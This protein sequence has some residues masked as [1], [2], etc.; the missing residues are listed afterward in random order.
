MEAS[1]FG[2]H[3]ATRIALVAPVLLTMVW[4]FLM[5]PR[6]AALAAPLLGPGAGWP[7]GH[8]ECSMASQKP[9]ISF[10]VLA[11]GLIVV[12]SRLCVT[13]AALRGALSAL[14]VLCLLSWCAL[15]LLSV[16]NT[17]C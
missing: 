1:R 7:L 14:L 13:N 9:A 17:T 12:T 11:A 6:P 5:Q 16:V 4:C 8:V 2:F 3:R 10:A 15:A